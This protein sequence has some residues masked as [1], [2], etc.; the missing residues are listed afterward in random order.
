MFY[1]LELARRGF[2]TLAPD[3]TGSGEHPGLSTYSNSF[4]SATMKGI[5][6]HIRAVDLLCSLPGVD[7]ER[8]GCCGHSLGGFNTMMVSVFEPRIRAVVS[9]C[10][11]VNW[12]A[13]ADREGS[14]SMMA[15]GNYMPLINRD[16]AC[17]PDMVPFDWHEVVAALAPRPLFVN[18][19]LRDDPFLVEGVCETIDA[20][21]PIYALYGATN[22]IETTHP[23]CGHGF[24]PEVREKAY[25]FLERQLGK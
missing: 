16:Y 11:Y 17:H 4:V 20:A 13:Y 7:P 23:D 14:L 10:G 24:P 12:Q 1:A 18:A 3:F 25:A 8:I 2:V 15:G 6:D 19:P 21:R 5:S 22:A 9:S